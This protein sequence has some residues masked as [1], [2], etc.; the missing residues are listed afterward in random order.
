MTIK[1]GQKMYRVRGP[2][3]LWAKKTEHLRFGWVRNEEMATFWRKLSHLKNAVSQ[4]VFSHE[5]N[6]EGLP[7]AA[8]EVVE[9]VVT[10]ERTRRK[11][12][13]TELDNFRKEKEDAQTNVR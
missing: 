10:L 1:S 6:L 8:L 4:G 9:Y 11:E 7:L 3:S 5:S 2:D 13:L 12:R